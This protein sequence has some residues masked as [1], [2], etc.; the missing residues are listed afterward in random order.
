VFIVDELSVTVILPLN[1]LSPLI[2][3]PVAFNIPPVVT[4]NLPLE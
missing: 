2:T 1:S 4:P 3:A